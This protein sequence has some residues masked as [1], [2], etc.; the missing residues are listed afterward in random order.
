MAH[1]PTIERKAN[2]VHQALTGAGFQGVG[3]DPAIII[4]IIMAII[5]LFKNCSL[6]PAQAEKRAAN[7]RLLDR[8]RLRMLI[9]QHSNGDEE[10]LFAALL[11]AGEDMTQADMNT[12]YS[13]A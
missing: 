9:R 2:E 10:A 13:E 6:S 1:Q 11:D 12:M 4:T 8:L 5:N 3:F 7:P